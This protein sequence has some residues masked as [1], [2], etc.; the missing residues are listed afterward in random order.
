MK[1]FNK[2][3]DVEDEPEGRQDNISEVEMP[4][5]EENRHDEHNSETHDQEQLEQ[6][7][8][9]QEITS[10]QINKVENHP[11]LTYEQLLEENKNLKKELEL[12]ASE[13]MKLDQENLR[14]KESEIKRSKEFA[15]IRKEHAELTEEVESWKSKAPLQI[16]AE[17]SDQDEKIAKLKKKILQEK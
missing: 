16:T 5:D 17:G 6:I 8:E 14:L 11:A 15:K 1:H 7:E 9:S 3:L 12:K 2:D 10:S 13:I 4:E